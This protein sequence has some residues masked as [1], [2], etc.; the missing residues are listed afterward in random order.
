MRD[1]R[2]RPL[3]ARYALALLAWLPE[4]ANAQPAYDPIIGVWRTYDDRTGRPEGLIR[5]QRVQGQYVGSIEAGSAADDPNARCT[6]CRGARHNQP[7]IGLAILEGLQ[8][9]DGTLTYSGGR[10]VDPET[11]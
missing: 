8:R 5:I 2:T 4:L 10:I 11:G 7:I 9:E 3:T 1:R 6:A